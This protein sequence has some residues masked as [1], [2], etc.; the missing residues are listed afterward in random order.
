MLTSQ[1][2]VSK[3]HDL[4]HSPTHLGTYIVDYFNFKVYFR[5]VKIILQLFSSFVQIL[6]FL[7][8]HD[9]NWPSNK[10]INGSKNH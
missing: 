6:G 9:S 4:F 8:Q 10:Q 1:V 5:T 2:S 3:G 7:P